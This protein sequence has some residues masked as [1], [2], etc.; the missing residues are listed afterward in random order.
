MSAN[1]E[2]YF[3][4]GRHHILIQKSTLRCAKEK[5]EEKSGLNLGQVRDFSCTTVAI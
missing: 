3:V 4:C 2:K 1:H 5:G